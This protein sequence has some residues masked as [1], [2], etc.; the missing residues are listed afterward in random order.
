MQITKQQVTDK[1]KLDELI[2]VVKRNLLLNNN[3]QGLHPVDFN[4][5]LNLIKNH[6]EFL[7]RFLMEENPTYKQIIP[8]LVFANND[9]LFLMQRKAKPSETRLRNKYSLGI[10]GHIRQEDMTSDSI[11]DWA[12]R[13]FYEE[14]NYSGSLII[15]PIGILNDDSNDVGKVHIGFVFLLIGNSDKISVKSELK[16]GRLISFEEC[17]S[18]YD[19]METWSQLVYNFLKTSGKVRK[20]S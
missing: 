5:Y 3:L 17:E 14:V 2:L 15:E 1:R 7:P 8:Y 19:N 10:G 16:D 11:I 6:Q 9:K 18:Y 20:F 12:Q 13:E 4:Y